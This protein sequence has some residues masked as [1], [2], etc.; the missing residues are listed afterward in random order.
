M[1]LKRRKNDNPLELPIP[2]QTLKA[3]VAY[4]VGGRPNS[5][6]RHL[7]LNLHP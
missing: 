6:D 3:M 7:V 4:M 5:E 1:A 2:E